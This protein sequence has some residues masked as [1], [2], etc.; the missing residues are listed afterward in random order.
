MNYEAQ[1]PVYSLLSKSGYLFPDPHFFFF[2]FLFE[3]RLQKMS[4]T[5]L[6]TETPKSMPPHFTPNFSMLLSPTNF[7]PFLRSPSSHKK[8]TF[9]LPDI[10]S[11]IASAT[12]DCLK[13]LHSLASHNPFLN[14]LIS[15][16]ADFQSLCHQVGCCV[17]SQ[18]IEFKLEMGLVLTLE[19]L[20][21]SEHEVQEVE[22]FIYSQ[23]RGGFARRLG[24]RTCGRKWRLQLLEL[25]QHSL[26]L[27]ACA[28][29]VP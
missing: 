9:A 20:S 8:P 2:I 4:Q 12:H 15:F 19:L 24:G 7:A 27:Q 1:R 25:V 5:E 3:P 23:L 21:G 13:H 6:A 18:F 29:L 28:D 26:G 16:H 22:D 11:S 17:C 14:K 10:Q